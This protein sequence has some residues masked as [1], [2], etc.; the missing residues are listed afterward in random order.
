MGISQS[1]SAGS[2]S[3]NTSSAEPAVGGAAT[4]GAAGAGAGAD[5]AAGA[6]GAPSGAGAAAAAPSLRNRDGKSSPNVVSG[7]SIF[8]RSRRTASVSG[9]FGSGTQQSTGHTAAHAS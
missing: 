3:A 1:S 5:L 8:A 9:I 6:T 2:A 4:G 7:W